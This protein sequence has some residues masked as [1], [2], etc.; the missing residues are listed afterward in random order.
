MDIVERKNAY[1]SLIDSNPAAFR[2]LLIRMGYSLKDF[3]EPAKR[4]N[5]IEEI[6]S[7]EKLNELYDEQKDKDVD[8]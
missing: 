4:T 5:I 2:K 1:L 3:D 7:D 6:C 8:R